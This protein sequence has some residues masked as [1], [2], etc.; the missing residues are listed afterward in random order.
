[1]VAVATGASFARIDRLAALCLL[2]LIVWVAFAG[3]LNAAIWML[4][5]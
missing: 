2:P 5:S 3:V 4:N 1:V